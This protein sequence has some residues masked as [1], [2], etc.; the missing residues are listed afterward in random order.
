MAP[1]ED[2]APRGCEVEFIGQ[3]EEWLAVAT[4]KLLATVQQLTA[5]A[6]PSIRA[7]FPR[8]SLADAALLQRA[9][10]LFPESVA[11]KAAG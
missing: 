8:P 1:S 2:T 7:R 10:S 9:L 5:S 4:A 11:V 6:P 3:A